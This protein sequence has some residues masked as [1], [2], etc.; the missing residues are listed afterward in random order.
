MLGGV[1][2]N[3]GAEAMAL[4]VTLEA[5]LEQAGHLANVARA[6]EIHINTLYGRIAELTNVLGP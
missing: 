6:R 2:P 4:R 5:Y 1:T 3:A